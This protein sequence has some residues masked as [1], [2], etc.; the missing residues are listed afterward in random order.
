MFRT[1]TVAGQ[2]NGTFD[3]ARVI[4]TYDNDGLIKLSGIDAN[5][6]W[7]SDLGP[8]TVF[9]SLNATYNIEF[10][11]RP[12]TGTPLLDYVGTTGT[13]LKGLNFGSSFEAVR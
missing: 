11:V 8:G 6:S 10:K 1:A 13:G 7:S 2:S 3:G 4:T 9:T 12:F 5:L